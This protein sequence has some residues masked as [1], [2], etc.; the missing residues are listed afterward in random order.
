MSKPKNET[1]NDYLKA[2]ALLEIHKG[3]C[4]VPYFSPLHLAFVEMFKTGLVTLSPSSTPGMVD[5][6]SINQTK[7]KL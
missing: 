4:S 2:N 7:K 1:L 3:S 6:Y 5:V